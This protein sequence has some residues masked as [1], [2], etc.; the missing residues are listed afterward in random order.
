[1]T[2]GQG[3]HPL[4]FSLSLFCFEIF[5]FAFLLLLYQFCPLH[6]TIVNVL[7]SLATEVSE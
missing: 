1:M 3:I 7:I 4:E 6:E 2:A 5:A